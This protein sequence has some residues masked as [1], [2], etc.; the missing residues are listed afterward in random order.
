ML[1]TALFLIKQSAVLTTYSFS[2]NYS[3]TIIQTKSFVK[4]IF[5][6][7]MAFLLVNVA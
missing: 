7:N 4:K 5:F 1:N 2:F 3:N 6:L